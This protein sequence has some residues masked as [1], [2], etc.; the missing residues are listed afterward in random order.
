MKYFYSVLSPLIAA[1]G[2]AEA[3]LDAFDPR[4]ATVASTQHDLFSGLTS[5]RHV[6]ESYLSR[7]E[8]INPHINAIISLNPNALGVADALDDRLAAGNVTGSLFCVTVLLKDNYNTRDMNTTG[9]S[10]ALA[11]SMPSADAPAV[12]AL[13]DAGA[14]ILGKANLHEMALEGLTVGSYGGQTINPYESTRTAGGSSGGSGAAVAASLAVFATGTDTVNSLR[15]PASANSLFSI[16]PTWGL[17][18]RAGVIPV[19]YS[20]DT[21]GPIARTI[22]DVAVAL[23]VM[24][25]VGYHPAD[26]ATALVPHKNQSIDYTRSLTSG[27]LRGKRFG[28]LEGF[29]NR[30]NASETT[31]VNRATSSMLQRLATAGATLVSINESIYDTSLIAQLDTQR[32]EFRESLTS[33]LVDPSLEGTHPSSMPEM[34]APNADDYLVIPAQYEY[35]RTALVSSTANA[36]YNLTRRGIQD[37]TLA[38]SNTFAANNLDAIVYPE[39]KNLVVPIGSPSQAGRNGILAALTGFPVVTIPAGFSAPSTSAPKGVPIGLEMLGRPWTEEGLLQMAY[40]IETGNN[41]TDPGD[42]R[43]QRRERGLRECARRHTRPRK[44]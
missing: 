27:S 39:Q 23:T 38:L 14:V 36:T 2:L 28:V 31:P 19:S 22:P 9:S 25:G 37:L 24:A 3:S 5:C 6:V 7:I 32:Y 35:V 10:L 4:E 17:I 12:A 44:R 15:S 34:Y 29:F 18:S 33:Y 41:E 8:A 43:D 40:Q 21:L 13:R 42:G 11:G 1:F 16:R 30:T 26:N 20:Q